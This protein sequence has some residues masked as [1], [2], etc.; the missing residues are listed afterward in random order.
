MLGNILLSVW[1]FLKG[2]WKWVI[3][4]ILLL[5]IPLGYFAQ[6]VQPDTNIE[7]NLRKG[8][9]EY[10]N[11]MELKNTF[12]DMTMTVLVKGRTINE[13]LSPQNQEAMRYIEDHAQNHPE[14]SDKVRFTISPAFFLDYM[15]KMGMYNPETMTPEDLILK[16]DGSLDPTF[17]SLFMVAPED[18]FDDP[19][20]QE[21]YTYIDENGQRKAYYHA[22]IAIG[23]W[24]TWDND[25][26]T[27]WVND[28]R[29]FTDEAGF[30]QNVTTM[31]GGLPAIMNWMANE[32]PNTLF[33]IMGI[34][35]VLM[36]LLLTFGFRVKGSKPRRW[37]VVLLI[38]LS[39]VFTFGICGMVD[40]PLTNVSV[41]AFPILLGMSV[42]SCVQTHNRY[43]EEIRKGKSAD[44]AAK[45]AIQRVVRPLWY[46]MTL[47]MIGFAS[48]L[49]VDEQQVTYFGITLIIGCAIAMTIMLMYLLVILY[50]MDKR[51]DATREP[52][53]RPA[54][55]LE[56]LIGWSVPKIAK[57]AIPLI[58][59][60]VIA[61][62]IGWYADE[63]WL[64][65]GG[66]FD[67]AVAHDVQQYKDMKYLQQLSGGVSPYNVI[68]RAKE[69]RSVLE[70][71]VLQWA[72]DRSLVAIDMGSPE[73]GHYLGA[74][75]NLG[76]LFIEDFGGL[77]PSAEAAESQITAFLPRAM[78][79]S[80]VNEDRT[81]LSVNFSNLSDL[82]IAATDSYD[83]LEEVFNGPD[84]MHPDAIASVD[85]SGITP[86]GMYMD[87][88]MEQSRTAIVTI[89]V[90]G[91]LL[92]CLLMFKFNWRRT[93]AVSFPI[94][95]VLGWSSLAMWFFG[96]TTDTMTGLLPA[97]LMAVGIELTILLLMRY[98]EE[99]DKGEHPMLTMTT[100]MSRIGR[101]IVVSGGMIFIG[102]FVMI[103]AFK[104]PGIQDFG[105]ITMTDMVLVILAVLVLMPALVLSFDLKFRGGKIDDPVPDVEE[106]MTQG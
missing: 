77:P 64:G 59:I 54:G 82:S 13:V 4:I 80:M 78:W 61:S 7:N 28:I 14:F 58:V 38:L 51:G 49:V 41:V 69:G 5:I 66:G 106:I 12:S 83:V 85:V 68:V 103:F 57:F 55:W 35:S 73:K 1:E 79:I 81:A 47:Q 105:L 84:A 70:P 42:D 8:S 30:D 48:V 74:Y 20:W 29:D 67:K 17:S 43:D 45:V 94:L 72:H 50:G 97:Q 11:I 31:V 40:V 37:L 100:A 89:G 36:L 104:F 44:E 56:K 21:N 76:S 15:A 22:I 52:D 99:R 90:G 10:N 6:Y 3:P 71:E 46:G 60:G 2:K 91:L 102:F 19:Y 63:E 32:L 24:K 98:Y 65:V 34:G 23:M 96:F 88:A 62:G 101:A 75:N 92:A 53:P 93:I 25:E 9:P 39:I 18:K 95:L 26:T 86:V 33:V 87:D 27:D 16:E